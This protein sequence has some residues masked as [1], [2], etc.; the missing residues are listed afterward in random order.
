M[1]E[2]HA[3]LARHHE[4]LLPP[5]EPHLPSYRDPSAV[6]AFLPGSVGQAALHRG[7]DVLST[8]SPSP[9]PA[10]QEPHQPSVAYGRSA[11]SKT[12]RVLKDLSEQPEEEGQGTADLKKKNLK[13]LLECLVDH[14]SIGE[15]IMQGEDGDGLALLKSL[16]SDSEADVRRYTAEVINR[17]STLL[18]GR[19]QICVS[20]CVEMLA[21]LLQDPSSADVRIASGKALNHLVTAMDARDE[22]CNHPE[23]PA[24]VVKVVRA[25]LAISARD[26][27]ISTPSL[28]PILY[29]CLSH[30]LVAEKA[31]EL[32]LQEDLVPLLIHTLKRRMHKVASLKVL[33][34]LCGHS[35]GKR[36]AIDNGGLQAICG[37]LTSQ[38]TVERQVCVN[39]AFNHP[40]ILDSQLSAR[41]T[42][43]MCVDESGKHKAGI[44]VP[45]L[46]QQLYS[47]DHDLYK[48][49]LLAIRS[50][51]ESPS[52]RVLVMKA[53]ED[54]PEMQ[55]RVHND[56]R[57]H[58]AAF[59]YE[60][61]SPSTA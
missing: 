38:E 6:S 45:N 32:A 58:L 26:S 47:T 20:G 9:A 57:V 40:V 30:L 49:A 13:V 42:L 59:R 2:H 22:I 35:Q 31:T 61:G 51:S 11:V 25:L 3:L 36:A 15:A 44:L 17:Y 43:L 24:V 55:A 19:K 48:N 27:E 52:T 23:G 53:L 14:S 8:R 46:V 29:E 7:S 56:H 60:T 39:F 34:S 4:G 10:A 28:I 18:Q 33:V 50:I 12:L 21:D 37:M 54:D 1:A 41:A 16:L 5:L